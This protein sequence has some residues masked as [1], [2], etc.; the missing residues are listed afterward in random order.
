MP[1][2][3][4]KIKVLFDELIDKSPFARERIYEDKH[5]QWGY[6]IVAIKEYLDEE[7]EKRK[8]QDISNWPPKSNA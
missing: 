1:K 5:Y 6:E 4:E 3:S 2:P 8:P 7:Y